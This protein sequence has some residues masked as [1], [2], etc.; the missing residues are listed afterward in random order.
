M[1]PA[2]LAYQILS[3][4]FNSSV[5]MLMLLELSLFKKR[6]IM[7]EISLDLSCVFFSFR[8]ANISLI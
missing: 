4:N 3:E 2:S 7:S 5:F 1:H 6:L 8:K